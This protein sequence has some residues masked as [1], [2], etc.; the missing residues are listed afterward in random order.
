MFSTRPFTALTPG[1]PVT[2]DAGEARRWAVEELLKPVY[3]DARPGLA[4]QI[5]AWLRRALLDFLDGLGTLQGSVGLLVVAGVFLVLVVAA[6]V[7]VP[8]RR[9]RRGTHTAAVFDAPVILTA[10]AHRDLARDAAARGELA[11]AVREQFR[12]IVRAA[13][14][15][16]VCSPAPG[17]TAAEVAAELG[18]A[19]PAHGR[20]LRRAAETFNAVRYGRAT[21]T[22]EMYDDL[23]RTD[24]ALAA[25]RPTY[26]LDPVQP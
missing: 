25:A 3:Q 5:L 19:F 16:D 15:R 9:N 2:P 10:A 24:Q 8:L 1:V 12:A 17:R 26:A 22:Q 11:A 7:L 14:E 18:R 23:R 20:Q 13:E 4:Q 21:P 6:I